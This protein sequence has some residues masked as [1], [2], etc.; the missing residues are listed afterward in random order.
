MRSG[1]DIALSRMASVF[2]AARSHHMYMFLNRRA[3]YLTVLVHNGFGLQLC[4]RP[5]RQGQF[6]RPSA[7]LSARIEL[8]SEQLRALLDGKTG[9]L[10]MAQA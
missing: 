10:R 7:H 5:L 1:M 4:A 2:G 3:N 9:R 8:T 6:V